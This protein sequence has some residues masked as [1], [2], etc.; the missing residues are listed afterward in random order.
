LHPANDRA[1]TKPN[2][3]AN[4]NR[5]AAEPVTAERKE[6]ITTWLQQIE[7]AGS[8]VVRDTEPGTRAFTS[9]PEK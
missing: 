7:V 5:R 9:A 1:T 2:R 6:F 3:A 8:R 4:P